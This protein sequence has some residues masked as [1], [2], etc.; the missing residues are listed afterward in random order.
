MLSEF[1]RFVLVGLVNT[2]VTYMLYLILLGAVGYLI[3]YSTSYVAGILLSYLLNSWFVFRTE[4]GIGSFLR[5]PLIYAGQ[6]LLG[7]MVLSF[8][9]EW[10]GVPRELGLGAAIAV[11]IPITFVASRLVLRGGTR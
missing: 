5:F 4:A 11:S 8:C 2:A 3:A 6:Y 10:L 1:R 7:A 9:V